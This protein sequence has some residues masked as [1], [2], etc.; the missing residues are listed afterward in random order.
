[1]C[2]TDLESNIKNSTSV[3]LWRCSQLNANLWYWAPWGFF[4]ICVEKHYFQA[5]IIMYWQHG[6]F[7]VPAVV[8]SWWNVAWRLI[9]QKMR[10]CW[11]HLPISLH[12]TRF[13]SSHPSRSSPAFSSNLTRPPPSTSTNTPLNLLYLNVSHS[14]NSLVAVGAQALLEGIQREHKVRII[15]EIFCLVISSTS[16]HPLLYM[17]TTQHLIFSS[18]GPFPERAITDCCI[19]F[20]RWTFGARRV[21]S[22]L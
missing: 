7:L 19:R 18:A 20:K 8:C 12:S 16:P 15:Q 14:P 22:T 10:F 21:W 17:Q 5:V 9:L 1:M 6:N 4:D 3:C 2:W 11:Q 13:F